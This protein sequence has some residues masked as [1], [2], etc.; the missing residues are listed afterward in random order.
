MD[1][2]I[3]H[4]M[5]SW[6]P[7]VEMAT[8]KDQTQLQRSTS[9]RNELYFNGLAAAA[10]LRPRL[11]RSTLR[12]SPYGKSLT[13]ER[14]ILVGGPVTE[15]RSSSRVLESES[16]RRTGSL[17]EK[18]LACVGSW[19]VERGGA[20]ANANE[21]SGRGTGLMLE[22]LKSYRRR[23]E[24]VKMSSNDEAMEVFSQDLKSLELSN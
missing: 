7:P 8:S 2:P 1:Y 10:P 17:E 22:T 12:F 13:E 11:G 18:T 15:E 6:S 23:K 5:A 20:K 16:F 9:E 24:E 21:E 4:F 3:Y 14:N 19:Q